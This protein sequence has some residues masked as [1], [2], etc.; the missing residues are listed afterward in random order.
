[1]HEIR[2][3]LGWVIVNAR[4]SESTGLDPDSGDEYLWASLKQVIE[5]QVDPEFRRFLVLD[6]PVE[7]L[8]EAN[9]SEHVQIATDILRLVVSIECENVLLK[10]KLKAVETNERRLAMNNQ[11]L[12]AKLRRAGLQKAGTSPGPPLPNTDDTLPPV[13][14]Q[15]TLDKSRIS[16]GTQV[17]QIST[18][19]P[20]DS[21]AI[22]RRATTE[23]T[24]PIN[25]KG[26]QVQSRSE[27]NIP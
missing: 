24:N 14:D 23:A 1:K 21:Q 18:S 10:T 7:A 22:A 5:A 16:S 27:E 15:I 20:F 8:R 9:M 26:R 4:E 25:C 19:I 11:G 2:P 12:E 13:S 3:I 17:A 6:H